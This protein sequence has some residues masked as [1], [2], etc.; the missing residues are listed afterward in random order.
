[1]KRTEDMDVRITF[2]GHLHLG[3]ISSALSAAGF[4]DGDRVC[5]VRSA[6][7][8]APPAIET[9]V[10]AGL[11]KAGQRRNF[12]VGRNSLFTV[13]GRKP[14]SPQFWQCRFDGTTDIRMVEYLEDHIAKR[15][16][17]VVDAV[18]PVSEQ[19]PPVRKIVVG[20]RRVLNHDPESPFT[21]VK[22]DSLP[23][24]WRVKYDGPN[25]REDTFGEEYINR[26]SVVVEAPAPSAP[27][28]WWNC[29]RSNRRDFRRILARTAEEAQKLA[30]SEPGPYFC[31]VEPL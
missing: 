5:V 16:L 8:E 17:I 24:Y 4:R 27:F 18:E 9:P 31:I 28:Q 6:D 26:A 12:N 15:S 29:Y 2:G 7:L 10:T 11:V 1:M 14:G 19:K 23:M 21:I 13:V 20:Q 30:N 25:G 22:Q 3:Q